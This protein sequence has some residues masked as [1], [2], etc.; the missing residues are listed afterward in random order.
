MPLA[1]SGLPGNQRHLSTLQPS[2]QLYTT[3]PTSLSLLAIPSTFGG[4]AANQLSHQ[5]DQHQATSP[6]SSSRTNP[7]MQQM[8]F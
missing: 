1:A 5:P 8:H 2:A 7:L 4:S 6:H 3:Q